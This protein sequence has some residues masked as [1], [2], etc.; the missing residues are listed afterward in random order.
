M[1]CDPNPVGP[2]LNLRRRP[3]PPKDSWSDSSKPAMHCLGASRAS[4]PDATTS[5]TRSRPLWASNRAG[6]PVFITDRFEAVKWRNWK[7]TSTRN[8]GTGGRRRS[9]SAFRA[10]RPHRRCQGE[11]SAGDDREHLGLRAGTFDRREVAARPQDVS[12]DR[13]RHARSVLSSKGITEARHPRKL[14]SIGSRGASM[15][16][17]AAFARKEISVPRPGKVL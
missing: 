17:C 8:S 4:M 15:R 12:P 2:K 10:L 7:M 11:V 5:S 9:N 6:F 16:I 14:A 3:A 13:G 1:V